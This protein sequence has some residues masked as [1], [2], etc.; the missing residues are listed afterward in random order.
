ML[1]VLPAD[2]QDRVGFATIVGAEPDIGVVA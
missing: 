1:R 2:D